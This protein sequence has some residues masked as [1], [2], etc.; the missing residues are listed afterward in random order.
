VVGDVPHLLRTHSVEC[1]DALSGIDLVLKSDIGLDVQPSVRGSEFPRSC[2]QR[3]GI[4]RVNQTRLST[5]PFPNR[6]HLTAPA[7]KLNARNAPVLCTSSD[8]RQ[9][10]R[11]CHRARHNTKVLLLTEQPDE[12]AQLRP[13]DVASSEWREFILSLPPH[14]TDVLYR[15]EV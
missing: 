6:N 15:C 13:I 4:T 9:L 2:V 1:F 5:E 10:G 12:L 8:H 3:C 7:R 14:A 11:T